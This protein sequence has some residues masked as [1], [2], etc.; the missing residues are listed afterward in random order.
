M[1]IK[2]KLAYL[3]L[4]L[5]FLLAIFLR[6]YRLNLNIPT[7]YADEAGHY[8]LL[9]ALRNHEFGIVKSIVNLLFTATWFL[10][11]NPL[12]VRFFSAVYGSLTVL[13]GYFF[14]KS[15]SNIS[16]SNLYLRVGLVYALLTAVLPWNFVISRLGHTHIPL[17]VIMSLLHLTLYLNSKSGKGK[18][19]SLIPFIIGGYL[20]PSLIIMSP[21]VLFLPVKDLILDNT[22]SKKYLYPAIGVF[23]LVILSVLVFKFRIFDNKARGLDLAIWRDV[24]V[25]ADSN[26]YRGLARLSSP[27]IFSFGLNTES[28]ANKLVFNY[29]ISIVSAFS[30]N[31]LSFFSPDFLF[32]K[33]DTVLRH[34]TGMVGNFYL[35]LLPFMVYGAFKFY[36]NI[37]TSNKTKALITLWIIASPLP[38]AITK[39]GAFYLLRVITLMPFLTYFVALGVVNIYEYF[40]SRILKIIF[41][42]IFSGVFIFSIY[43]Y[44]FGYFH[45][46][47]SLSASSYEFGFKE[48]SD[49][50]TKNNSKIIVIWDDKY[51]LNVFC[52]WQNLP[53]E[54]CRTENTNSKAM[55][56]NSRV[57]V[58]LPN[59]IFSLPNSSEDFLQIIKNY[60]PKY[61]AL[62]LKYNKTF[63]NLIQKYKLLNTIK[64]PDQSIAFEIYEI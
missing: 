26:L 34:S 17:I 47:P 24:N 27:S 58:A 14:A 19:I 18:V 28:L 59:L 1:T 20:Y 46:Y 8:F 22:V 2:T 53:Y 9:N 10:G 52:F 61:I 25:T 11:L 35:F 37:H 54:I 45:V 62:P 50:Q 30:K 4:F 6:F 31:Y 5:I 40:T 44:F 42:I 29:P 39:D 64:N 33:G 56:G 49:F 16:G 15:L 38:A 55:V 12:G 7:I 21:L 3:F 41:T 13:V 63:S 23:L 32:L 57:D 43:Y 60:S 51:P 36:S 48:I